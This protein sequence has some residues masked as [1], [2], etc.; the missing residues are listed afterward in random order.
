MKSGFKKMYTMTK[1]EAFAAVAITL[2]SVAAYS[3]WGAHL[4][5]VQGTS[6]QVVTAGH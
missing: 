4:I 2:L 3:F 6:P 5:A 1:S